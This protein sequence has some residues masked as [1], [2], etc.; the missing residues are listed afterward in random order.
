MLHGGR[1]YCEGRSYEL[2]PAT[3]VVLAGAHGGQ[4]E[5]QQ[6]WNSRSYLNLIN[7]LFFWGSI[8]YPMWFI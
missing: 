3:R 8:R 5:P 4:D 2:A 7:M 6:A 1:M